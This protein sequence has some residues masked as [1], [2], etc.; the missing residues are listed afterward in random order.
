MREGRLRLVIQPV[1]ARSYPHARIS[2][3]Y[4][5]VQVVQGVYKAR[6]TRANACTTCKSPCG[7]PRL[8]KSRNP[9]L[10]RGNRCTTSG[11]TPSGTRRGYTGSLLQPDPGSAGSRPAGRKNSPNPDRGV[12]RLT[13]PAGECSS[14]RSQRL[15]GAY[16]PGAAVSHSRPHALVVSPWPPGLARD[17]SEP[18]P[19]TTRDLCRTMSRLSVDSLRKTIRMA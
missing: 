14:M 2:T 1:R 12:G 18:H 8:E 9:R 5:V 19:G 15:R 13:P 6:L 11:G 4:L 16:A 17:P 10:T 3:L 7:T